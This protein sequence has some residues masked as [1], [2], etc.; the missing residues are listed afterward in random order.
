[1]LQLGA[2]PNI[3]ALHYCVVS[4]RDEFLMFTTFV[5]GAKPLA[6]AVA[7][8]AL[9]SGAI[10][11]ARRRVAGVLVDVAVALEFCHAQG[12]LHQDVKQDNVLLGADGSAKL[13]DFGLASKGEGVDGALR[14]EYKGCTPTYDSPEV[15]AL[16]ADLLATKLDNEAY[17]AMKAERRLSPATHDI[18]AFGAMAAA[19]YTAPAPGDG[20]NAKLASVRERPR[21]PPADA[22]ADAVRAWARR[23]TRILPRSSRRSTGSTA[24]RSARST[25]SDI[26]KPPL[27]THG[28]RAPAA[29][30]ARGAD[31]RAPRRHRALRRVRSRRALRLRRGAARRARA[32]VASAARRDRAVRARPDARRPSRSRSQRR[33]RLFGPSRVRARGRGAR[34]GGQRGRGRRGRRE[35]AGRGR[36]APRGR[37]RRRDMRCETIVSATETA[38]L[39]LFAL[40]EARARAAT[41]TRAPTRSSRALASDVSTAEASFVAPVAA[42]DTDR[43]C[44][45]A[46]A[47]DADAVVDAATGRATRVSERLAATPI[48]LKAVAGITPAARDRE[49]PP[50]AVVTD[51]LARFG[52]AGASGLYLIEGGGASGKSWILRALVAELARARARGRRGRGGGA[53]VARSRSGCRSRR[54]RRT[55]RSTTPSRSTSTRPRSPKRGTR[56]GSCCCST[57]STRCRP[58]AAPASSTPRST[59]PRAPAPSSCSRRGRARPTPTSSRRSA[60]ASSRPCRSAPRPSP[61][62]SASRPSPRRRSS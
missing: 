4:E 19:L 15:L 29:D 9:Q 60:S 7:S 6:D 53:G 42:D 26:G 31:G 50:P 33:R 48:A 28:K 10:G 40:A 27:L 8:K 39:A 62:R 52:I 16:R 12:V 2:H 59:A 17:K 23:C 41:T 61:P 1:M 55:S 32:C 37:R 24:R 58:R 45:A 36:R 35:G 43:A 20:G 34:G 49:A 22:S 51:A 14:A 11:A 47:A 5:D 46:A 57:G 3:V 13:M 30:R 25:R 54:S 44:L 18:F 21:F 56:A 38:R